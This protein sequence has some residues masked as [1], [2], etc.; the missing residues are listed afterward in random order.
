MSIWTDTYT[1]I[2]GLGVPI[3]ANTLIIATGADWPDTYLVYQEVSSVSAEHADNDEKI[4]SRRMQVAG[5]CRTGLDGLPDVVAAM[6]AAGFFHG[7]DR[8]LPYN[9]D[10][11][12]YGLVME[13]VKLTEE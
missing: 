13:F 2:S 10:T 3:S 9:E 12:H 5:Y 1:A 8:E 6:T 7:P 4:R 11:R